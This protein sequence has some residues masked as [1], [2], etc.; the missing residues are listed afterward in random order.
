MLTGLFYLLVA[1]FVYIE[2]MYILD[3][4]ERVSRLDFID[5][6]SKDVKNNNT[7]FENL[8]SNEKSEAFWTVLHGFTMI[9]VVIGG[10]VSV[11]WPLWASLLIFNMLLVAPI[12]KLAKKKHGLTYRSST[13]Y[14]SIVW[15]N[16][17]FG[18]GV[19]AFA[20][21]NHYHLLIDLGEIVENFFV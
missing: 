18:F 21:I 8:S 20:L 5:N 17:L 19:A 9:I 3:V 15:V 6:F 13:S 11:Q 16:S 10:L 12:T 14:L 1:Y 7:T 2:M 4:K